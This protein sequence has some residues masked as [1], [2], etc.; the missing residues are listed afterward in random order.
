MRACGCTVDLSQTLAQLSLMPTQQQQD[1]S[2]AVVETHEHHLR[3]RSPYLQ[4]CHE[5]VVAHNR[6]DVGLALFQVECLHFPVL[7]VNP[8]EHQQIAIMRQ[9]HR[10]RKATRTWSQALYAAVSAGSSQ[11]VLLSRCMAAMSESSRLYLAPADAPL[12]LF[13]PRCGRPS[14]A[15]AVISCCIVS[16][17]YMFR[18]VMLLKP[19]RYISRACIR[20]FE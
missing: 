19:F 2:Y 14:V 4:L 20:G 1:A 5:C 12:P 3:V 10:A 11:Y 17:A 6:F 13:G 18:L 15:A 16:F 7:L 8:A 9:S